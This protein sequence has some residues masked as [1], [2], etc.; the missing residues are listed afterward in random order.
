V[1]TLFEAAALPSLVRL[2]S[3]VSGGVQL[4]SRPWGRCRSSRAPRS[5]FSPINEVRHL[6]FQLIPSS[7]QET[8]PSD[9]FDEW[10]KR[11]LTCLDVFHGKT[12][13]PVIQAIS[14]LREGYF[15]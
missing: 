4:A 13:N 10:R 2:F 14:D 1:V 15:R 11:Q 5:P 7:S 12:C 8:G 6:A 3:V 9:E